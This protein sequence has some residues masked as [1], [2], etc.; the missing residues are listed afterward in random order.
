MYVCVYV[1]VCGWTGNI[2]GKEEMG[3]FAYSV[4]GAGTMPCQNKLCIILRA[5]SPTELHACTC[6]YTC[7]YMSC[8]VMSCM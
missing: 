4:Q 5:S 6:R 2:G 3:R 8:H 1:C 7:M